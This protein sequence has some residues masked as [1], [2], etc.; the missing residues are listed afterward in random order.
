MR[1]FLFTILLSC[2]VVPVS[3]TAMDACYT[4]HWYSPA[5]NGEGITLILGDQT[6]ALTRYGHF[7]GE[8]NYWAASTPN[9][10]GGKH[11]FRAIQTIRLDGQLEQFDV[12]TMTITTNPPENSRLILSWDYDID[13]T[14]L[15]RPGLPWCDASPSCKG[16]R[17]LIPLFKPQACK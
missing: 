7:R 1:T 12:G 14:L 11:I 9:T 17:E 4:G 5:T 8:P 15:G 6:I 3:A 16:Q 2:F 13:L 10:A